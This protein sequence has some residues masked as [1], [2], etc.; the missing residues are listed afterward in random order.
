MVHTAE[1]KSMTTYYPLESLRKIRGVN[2]YGYEQLINLNAKSYLESSGLDFSDISFKDGATEV[3]Y[4]N[5]ADTRWKDKPYGKT[6]TI[7][8]VVVEQY[9]SK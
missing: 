9:H 8:I 4:Y 2:Q 7:E 6:G 1:A 5:Q 3:F